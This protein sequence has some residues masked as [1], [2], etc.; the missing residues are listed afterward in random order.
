MIADDAPIDLPIDPIRLARW[1]GDVRIVLT[2][3]A[4]LGIG[5]TWQIDDATLSVLLSAVLMLV[6]IG[7]AI[8][9]RIEKW[10]MQAHANAVVIASAVASAHASANTVMA[11][12][13]LVVVP[14]AT[15]DNPA[16]TATRPIGLA[17]MHRAS[18]IVQTPDGSIV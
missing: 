18:A 2:V 12:V 17:E 15:V 4:T 7:M 6:P 14:A 16:A 3:L 9:G 8:W 5:K 13:P 10:H 11:M 1:M